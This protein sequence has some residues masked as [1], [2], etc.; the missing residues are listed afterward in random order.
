M[1]DFENRVK[2]AFAQTPMLSDTSLRVP[3]IGTVNI[4]INQYGTG[5]EMEQKRRALPVMIEDGG[6]GFIT[7]YCPAIPGCVSQGR[8]KEEA[9][10]NIKEAID[11]CIETRQ[12]MGLPDFEEFIMLEV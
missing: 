6:N 11:L 8:T 7:V 10:E 9:L 4:T 2:A 1:A 12:E 5:A 3:Y